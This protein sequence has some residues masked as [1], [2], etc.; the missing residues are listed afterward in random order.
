[1]AIYVL[2]VR[3]M[4]YYVQIYQVYEFSELK[5]YSYTRLS[6]GET[7]VSFFVYHS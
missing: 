4:K 3:R 1:M 5:K 7:T 6:S 2:L